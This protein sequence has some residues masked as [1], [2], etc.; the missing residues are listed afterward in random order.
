MVLYHQNRIEHSYIPDLRAS[1]KAYDA[2]RKGNGINTRDNCSVSD[3]TLSILRNLLFDCNINGTSA[4]EKHKSL[5]IASYDLRRTR[6]IE[7]V[8]NSS[9][10]ATP[11]SK[12]LWW[13]ICLLARLRLAFQ[14]FKDIA[15][16]LPNFERVTIVL[17]LRPLVPVNPSQRPLNLKQTFD[18]L[19]LDLGPA[20]TKAVLGLNWTVANLEREFAKRQNQKPNVHAEVQ[21]LMSLNTN[22][23]S[24]SGLFPYFGCSKLSCFMCNRFLQS[25]GRFTT[26][27]C[28]G[29]LFKPWTVPN[30]DRLLP[31]EADRTVKTLMFVQKEVK[32]KLK[33]SVEGHIRHERTSV[34]GGSSVL[35]CRQEERSKRQLQI[36]RLKM[37]AD[38]DRV[39]EMFRR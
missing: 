9:P 11:K 18:I 37:K 36:D 15:L 29:R 35:D 27:G 31:G 32:K 17:V 25:D 22:E 2:I 5:V 24:T 14:N 10:S 23:L 4:L 38:R 3:A 21:M 12:S 19:Q 16:T 26:R 7:E 34:I 1:F 30:L 20:T 8:L 28:H 33:A 13:N 39:A 6:S